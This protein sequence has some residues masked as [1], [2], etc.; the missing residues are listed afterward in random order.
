MAMSKVAKVPVLP[1]PKN[2][3]IQFYQHSNLHDSLIKIILIK[4]NH[5]SCLSNI[6]LPNNEQPLVGQ[7]DVPSI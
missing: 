5:M 4:N 3:K 7:V 2:D 1:I 6:Y